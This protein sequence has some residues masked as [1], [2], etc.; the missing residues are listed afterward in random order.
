MAKG[1]TKARQWIEDRL[2][3][4]KPQGK[5]KRGLA[6][7]LKIAPS[8]VTNIINGTR[9]IAL[10]EVAPLAKYL[11]MDRAE[12]EAR[13]SGVNGKLGNTPED[14]DS[15]GQQPVGGDMETWVK[16]GVMHLLSGVD[17]RTAVRICAEAISNLSNPEAEARPAQNPS[18]R[19]K[20]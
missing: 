9:E 12:V 15:Q 6:G 10:R 7:A 5:K 3:Q 4:L 11:E 20:R 13:L 2:L 8:A 1:M 19:E 16:Q 14:Q 18:R 17:R